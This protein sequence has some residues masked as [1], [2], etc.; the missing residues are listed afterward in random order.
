M[1]RYITSSFLISFLIGT[2]SLAADNS[3]AST[4]HAVLNTRRMS[5]TSNRAIPTSTRVAASPSTS[6]ILIDPGHGGRDSG[7]R[8]SHYQEAE[9]A[10]TWSLELKKY[11]SEK[12]FHVEMTRNETS[13]LSLHRRIQRANQKK[14]DLVISLHANSLIDAR[15][16][17][18][19]YYV[20]A[21]LDMEDQK[22][23]L[24]YEEVQL[25][26]NNQKPVEKLMS[27]NEEQRSQV[28]AIIQDLQR[29]SYQNESLNLAQML[30][31]SWKGQIKQG[32]FDL[33]EQSKSPA[34]LIELGYMSNPSDL[35]NLL[36]PQFRSEKAEK[37]ASI[38]A[39]FL[40]NNAPIE[41]R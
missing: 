11:L 34:L 2:T 7:A 17:G 24:A 37:L 5:T 39:N 8:Q 3:I 35:K 25:K 26:K 9:I 38:V 20:T 28:G 15:V 36:N 6:R 13:G 29:Q 22:L 33:L 19:E 32:P 27:F 31:Q 10:W 16:K 30:N 41:L 1:L 4:G 23:Q 12:G 14:Y 18:I 40:K 21:P